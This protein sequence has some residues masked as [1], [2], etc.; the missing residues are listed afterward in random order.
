[1]TQKTI[2]E[3]VRP[4]AGVLERLTETHKLSTVM[5]NAESTHTWCSE[6][7]RGPCMEAEGVLEPGDCVL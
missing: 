1:M 3:T 6:G 4:K 7:R 5:I 2:V